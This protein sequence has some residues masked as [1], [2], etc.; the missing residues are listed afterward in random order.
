ML[1]GD[2]AG[3]LYEDTGKSACATCGLRLGPRGL[4][5]GGRRG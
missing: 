2:I 5:G 3:F 4:L 1:R